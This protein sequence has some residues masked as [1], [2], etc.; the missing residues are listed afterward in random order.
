MSK[1]KKQY[2]YVCNNCGAMTA[3]WSGQCFDC[4][5]WDCIYED[6]APDLDGY[7]SSTNSG[8]AAELASI[9]GSAEE[10]E[11][12]SSSMQELDRVLGGGIVIGSAILIGGD[13]G[14]GKSTLL[15]QLV[16]N[17][18]ASNIGCLY[19]TGEESVRQVQL[20]AKRLSIANDKAQ[21]VAATNLKNVIA[22]IE[23]VK[24]DVALVV[25]DSIQ[26]MH[27]EEFSSAPGTVS[28]IRGCAARLIEYAKRNDIIM[29][30]VGHVTKDG[31]IAGPKVLEHMVDTVLYFEGDHNYHY[32]ILRSMKNRFGQVGEI[33][34]FEMTSF[35]L[36]EIFNPSELF[37]FD[38]VN[39]VS[40]NAVFCSIEGSRPMLVEVQALVAPSPM[41]TPRRSVVGWDHN[42]LSM[43]IAV[44]AVRYGLNLTTHEVYLSIAG[45]MKV[46]EPAADL[47]VAA[48]L[49][50][51]ATN[52][53]LPKNSAFFGEVGLSGEIRRVPQSQMRI[54]E[55]AKLGFIDITCGDAGQ[56]D[57]NEKISV[58]QITHLKQLKSLF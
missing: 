4:K 19:I 35:G 1:S 37:L 27:T 50:S 20:R 48:A 9:S 18:A 5:E 39:N 46:S 43:I 12:I 8:K 13:P 44:L 25:I 56:I 6:I 28:Q 45:G 21:V 3:K 24:K 51:A 53:P 11:R 38:R 30:L 40:G 54:S 33:G 52:K 31:Q 36:K 26:T 17:L 16:V 49:I 29:I 22:T 55:A 15:L 23:A 34:V 10:T 57:Q 47:A 41:P 2:K 58:G 32:R 42:R 7:Y 14:I